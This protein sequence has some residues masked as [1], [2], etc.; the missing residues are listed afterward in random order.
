MHKRGVHFV[1]TTSTGASLVD[2]T[3]WDGR[4]IMQ[5]YHDQGPSYLLHL[6]SVLAMAVTRGIDGAREC[7]D[8]IQSQL[9]ESVMPRFRVPGQARFSIDPAAPRE[10]SRRA[11]PRSVDRAV[12]GAKSMPAA[13]ACKSSADKAGRGRN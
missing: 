7:Y 11:Q 4:T 3:N 1:A 12:R 8:Y 6:R 5:Q 13:M 9:T 10:P 2:T